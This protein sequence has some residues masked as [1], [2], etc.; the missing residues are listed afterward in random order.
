MKSVN[1]IIQTSFI[2]QTQV[3]V[4]ARSVLNDGGKVLGAKILPFID[5]IDFMD[6]LD[7][8]NAPVGPLYVPYG[9]T[10]LTK[11]AR[12]YDW[13][14]T[15]FNDNFDTSVWNL[16]RDDMLN[17]DCN[18]MKACEV[19]DFLKDYPNDLPLFVRPCLDLKAFNGTLTRVD[20]IKSWM[21][22]AQAGNHVFNQ[23]TMVSLA[24]AKQILAEWRWFVVDGKVIDG[25]IYRLRGQR[26]TIHERDEA[27]IKEAQTF[28]DKWLPHECCVMDLALTDDGMKCIE[29]NCMNS[30]GFYNNDIQK[31]VCSVNQYM[32]ENYG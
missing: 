5:T 27:V 23:D 17:S 28:A 19:E 9:A 6:G 13:M 24:P 22:A 20:E 29:F 1:W 18:I 3:E 10:K 25:S 15:F 14:G 4:L 21:N 7:L 16:N 8:I 11:L 12:S 26:L 30:S 2:D 32:L 31:I